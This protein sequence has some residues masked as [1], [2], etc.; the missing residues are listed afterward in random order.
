MGAHYFYSSVTRCSDL[1]ER[2]FEVR[3]RPRGEWQAADFVLGEATGRRNELFRCETKTGRIAEL[4]P[5]DLVVGALGTREATLEGVGDWREIGDDLRMD[6]LTGAGLFGRA[7][8]TSPLMPEFMPLVYR[9]HLWRDGRPLGM[10]DF[11]KPVAPAEP[12]AAIVLVIG[13]SMSAGKT[14]S[15][16]V[17]IRE[18]VA[19]GRRV[20]AAK[21]TGAARFRDIV[22]F[23]D[24]GAAAVFDFVD[25]GLP[26][27]VCEE[28]VYAAAL[29][30]LLSRIAGASPD[31][32][33]VEAGASPLEPYNGTLAVSRIRTNTRMTVLCASDPYAVLGV[34]TAFGLKPDL[35]AGPAANTSAAVA[36]VGRLACVPAMSLIDAHTRDAL[37]R[38]LADRLSPEAKGG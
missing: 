12:E 14:S 25:E 15:G 31:V 33:V 23:R 10:G 37:R 1:W 4:V 13:T 20:V 24:A 38:M 2:P 8:S 30:R 28:A 19:M 22:S 9:G 21:L 6:A 32:V 16:R 35:V 11:V 17:I 7:T 29:D 34:Q 5:G 3:P 26:S 36:L 18:L 27:T